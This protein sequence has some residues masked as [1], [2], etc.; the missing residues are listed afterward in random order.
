MT[1]AVIAQARA[2]SV[3]L[4]GKV[5]KKIGDD[6]VLSRVIRRARAIAGVDVV[7]VATS[8]LAGDDPVAREAE[9]C[10]AAVF[11]GDERDVL[12]RY[13][14][15]ARCLDAQ[16]II[17]ITCDCP[18][19]DPEVCGAVLDVF[20]RDDADYASNVATASWPH[21]LDCEVF[22]RLMLERAA[23][24]AVADDERE[25]VTLWMRRNESLR[26]TELPGPGG[27]AARQRW[28]LDYPEDLEFFQALYPRLPG[29]GQPGWREV[30]EVL[31]AYPEISAIN[32]K[33]MAETVA[34]TKVVSQN[35]ARP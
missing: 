15:A 19:I 30:M 23:A 6:T 34:R 10:G 12:S 26:H 32:D 14:D 2:G 3:R 9:R 22:S 4:P 31:E 24:E 17:R 1:I 33:R 28:V 13:R 7:C 16:T 27:E 25:H 8:S 21:G 29:T 5:L 18:L 20:R 11:R 35:A